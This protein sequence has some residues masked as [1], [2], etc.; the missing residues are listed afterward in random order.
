MA[1]RIEGSLSDREKKIS[2]LKIN[3]AINKKNIKPILIGGKDDFYVCKK[4]EE[5]FPTLQNLCLKTSF[6]DIASCF[7][8]ANTSL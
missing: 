6:F 5:K 8:N 1:K 2:L 4:I 7:K 3:Y